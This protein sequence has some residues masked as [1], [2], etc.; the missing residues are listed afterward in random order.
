MTKKELELENV[1]LKNSL[2][3][4]GEY[5]R[6]YD[7]SVDENRSSY[8]IGSTMSVLKSV[9]EN[10]ENAKWWGHTLDYRP[11]VSKTTRIYPDGRREIINTCK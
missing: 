8:F 3:C 4:I 6:N 5:L 10:L 1:V 7:N 2:D 9:N 11:N